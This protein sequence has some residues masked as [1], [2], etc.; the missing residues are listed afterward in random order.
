MLSFRD[1]TE[2]DL[3]CVTQL[4]TE[5]SEHPWKA[6]HFEDSLGKSGYICCIA[7]LNEQHVGHGVLMTVADEAHL[8]I[9]TISKSCQGK[10]YGK[11]LLQHLV[12]QARQNADTLFLEVRESNVSA[13]NLYLNEGL[14]E[15]GRRKNYYPANEH[16]ASE[17]AIV[18]A[19]D[20]SV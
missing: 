6:R 11:Q 3:P 20:L 12:M 8:L 18:M 19:L 2:Q 4:E 1:M 14:G 7:S 10:G 15:I 13:F 9:I 16:H 17:D 5:A